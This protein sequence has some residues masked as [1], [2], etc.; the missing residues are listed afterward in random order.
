M[1]R[2]MPVFHFLSIFLTFRQSLPEAQNAYCFVCCNELFLLSGLCEYAVLYLAAHPHHSTF[3]RCLWLTLNP[4][5]RLKETQREAAKENEIFTHAVRDVDWSCRS[6]RNQS[7]NH[8]RREGYAPLP[9]REQTDKNIFVWSWTTFSGK[10]TWEFK[11]L[12]DFFLQRF[13]HIAVFQRS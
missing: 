7:Q 12:L 8:V 9:G 1:N 2:A 11:R 5:T 4:Q 13:Y 6:R 10:R 3:Q